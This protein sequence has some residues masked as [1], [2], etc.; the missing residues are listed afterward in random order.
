MK[1]FSPNLA[2]RPP[3]VRR[4]L[5]TA[6]CAAIALGMLV[7]GGPWL[8]SQTPLNVAVQPVSK[9]IVSSSL[10]KI[11]AIKSFRIVQEKDGSALEIL[12]TKPLAP[13]IQA[14]GNPDRLVIDLPNARLETQGKRISVQADQISAI[15]ADQFRQNPPVARLVV[16]L[17]AP[18]AYSWDAAGNRL[19]VHFGRNPN[20]PTSSP[21]QAPTVPSLMPAPQPVVMAVRAAGSLA[22]AGNDG[23]AGS[24]ITAGPDTAVLN[25]SSGG[26]VHVCPGTTVSVTPSQNRHKLMFSMNTG[27][28]ETHFAL[29]TSSDSVMTPDFRILLAGPGE[30]HYAISADSHGNTCVRAL[31]GN[32]ASAMISELL[33]DRTYQ[34]KVTDQLVFRSGQLDRV[35]MAVPLECGCPPPRDTPLRADSNLPTQSQAQ[36]GAMPPLN[37]S[38]APDAE[39]AQAGAVSTGIPATAAPLDAS[40]APTELHVQIEAPFVFHATGPP[41]APVEEVRALPLDSRPGAAPVLAA[42]LPPSANDTLKPVDTASSHHSPARRLFRKIGGFFAALFR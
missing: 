19:V 17:L 36:S 1:D 7:I 37:A 34:V 41:P 9:P 40:A 28:L 8:R 11:A 42:R 10:S 21:F 13:A 16:D 35:D 4:N 20:E 29:D 14:I 2:V 39:T 12:S 38:P 24:S 33:G 30:F 26:E 15:R 27:A 3:L 18:R 32:T 23:G 5:W 25:L 31:P 22:L 6:V